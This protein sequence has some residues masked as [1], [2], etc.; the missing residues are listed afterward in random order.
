MFTRLADVGFGAFEKEY[1]A[2]IC[3]YKQD[4][5][6]MSFSFWR[7]VML[8]IFLFNVF[9]GV[10]FAAILPDDPPGVEDVI[11][12]QA[13]RKIDW[14]DFRAHRKPPGRMSAALSVCGI[15]FEGV[16]E[17]RRLVSV[18]IA[19]KFYPEKSWKHPDHL[20]PEVL[21][22]EQLHFDITELMGRR[23]HEEI[24]EL[25]KKGKLNARSLEKAYDKISK[26]HAE[27]QQLYDK[28]TNHSLNA[29]LQEW[30][31]AYVSSELE[32]TSELSGYH[33]ILL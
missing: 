29:R 18:K 9:T 4:F 25:N 24:K 17:N 31:S 19:V 8:L 22:H 33:D 27:M 1:F 15:G 10:L 26:Q 5:I 2:T 13:D 12:W 3:V 20:T 32:K 28:Q 11:L 23:F 16:E 30:W 14:S 21:A 6:S 7:P